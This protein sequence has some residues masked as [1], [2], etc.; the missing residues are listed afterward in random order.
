MPSIFWLVG[1]K[2]L[3]HWNIGWVC[4]RVSRYY[5]GKKSEGKRNFELS[6]GGDKSDQH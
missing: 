5:S 3:F 1:S 4:G 6:E 2:V